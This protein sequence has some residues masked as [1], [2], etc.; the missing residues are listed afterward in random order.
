MEEKEMN[1]IVSKATLDDL[2][3]GL[4]CFKTLGLDME[5]TDNNRICLHFSQID[6][7]EPEQVFTIDIMLDNE[8]IVNSCPLLPLE[9]HEELVA[10]LNEKNDIS[11]F[12]RIVRKAFLNQLQK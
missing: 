10:P 11:L 5:K 2:T 4:M 12:V 9:T 6:P 3:R 1:E 8:W 7:A